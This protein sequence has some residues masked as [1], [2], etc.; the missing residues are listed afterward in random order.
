MKQQIAHWGEAFDQLSRRERVMIALAVVVVIGML[1]YLPLESLLTQSSRVQ[2]NIKALTAE[3]R[4]SEQQIDLYQQTLATDPDQEYRQRL[5][6]LQQQ[7]KDLDQQL[8][9]QMVDMVPADKMPTMLGELLGRV[10]GI[11]LQSFESLAPKP[12]LALGD[13]NKLNLYSHGIKLAFE[14]D[15]FATLK[16]IEAVEAMPNKLYWRQLDYVVGDY[17]KAEVTLEVYTLSI[18]KDFISVANQD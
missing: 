16:F 6:G 17:P 14:G 3:N 4:I 18:N 10:K 12:L 15:Y 2:S 11:R 5:M 9:F 1:L 13:E 7:E 8:S